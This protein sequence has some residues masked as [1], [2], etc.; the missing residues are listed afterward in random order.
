[1]LSGFSCPPLCLPFAVITAVELRAKGRYFVRLSPGHADCRRVRSATHTLV[2]VEILTER[3]N[4][5]SG[6]VPDEDSEASLGVPA[7]VGRRRRKVALLGDLT[8]GNGR[9]PVRADRTSCRRS[10]SRAGMAPM[11]IE[12]GSP[13]NSWLQYPCGILDGEVRTLAQGDIRPRRRLSRAEQPTTGETH[14][15]EEF[16]TGTMVGIVGECS[17]HKRAG[18]ADDHE[19]P[20]PSARILSTRRVTPGRRD[21]PAPKKPAARDGC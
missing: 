4:D 9:R 1:M 14:A 10:R 8:A 17:G 3:R 20:K 6:P 11:P 7:T 13:S 5:Q 21:V 15:G 2:T 12:H 19:R 16:S 18:V